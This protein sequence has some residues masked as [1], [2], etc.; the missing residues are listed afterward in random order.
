NARPFITLRHWSPGALTDSADL[1]AR[2]APPP[3]QLSLF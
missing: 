2:F 1:R 3:E